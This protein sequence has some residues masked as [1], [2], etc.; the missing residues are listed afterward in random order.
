MANRNDSVVFESEESISDMPGVR[1]NK[2]QK[3][4]SST[5]EAPE[6]G[7]VEEVEVGEGESVTDLVK[8]VLREMKEIRV[9]ISDMKSE[10]REEMSAFKKD[11]RNEVGDM[12][13]EEIKDLNA[14]FEKMIGTVRDEIKNDCDC[15]MR[16]LTERVDGSEIEI[17]RLRGDANGQMNKIR[18]EIGNVKGDTA[19]KM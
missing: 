14:K 13:R 19:V 16:K 9:E 3:A 10:L 2:R 7:K 5:Q 1:P 11:L 18:E 8:K 12:V 6:G 15:F 4:S 17:K